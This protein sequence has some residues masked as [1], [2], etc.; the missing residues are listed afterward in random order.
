MTVNH[1][2]LSDINFIREINN[3]KKIKPPCFSIA[4]FIEKNRIMPASSPLPGPVDL[5][6]T[7]Y[8]RE[9][10]SNMSPYS[11]IQHQIIK[12]S[13]QVAATFAVENIMG[14]Y[15][16][17]FP[18]AILYISA[19]QALLEKF[20]TKRLEPLIDSCGIRP[21]IIENANEAFGTKSRRTGDKIFS[22]Q[23]VS[24]F[25]EL[26]SAQSPAS[27]RSDTIRVLIRDETEGAKKNL[28]TG[29]GSFL[30]VSEARVKFFGARKKITDLSTPALLEDSYIDPAY[31]EGDKRLYRMPCPECGKFIDFYPIPEEGNFGLRGIIEKGRL[32]EVYYICEHCQF[33]IL[34]KYKQEM[35]I[36][37]KWVPTAISKSEFYRSYYINSLYSPVGT[38]AWSDYYNSWLSSKT[39]HSK[40]RAFTNLAAGLSYQEKG[41]RPKFSAITHLRGNYKRMTLPKGV[42]F[43]T[44]TIDVQRG[45]QKFEKMSDAEI[46]AY[47]KKNPD[48]KEKYPRLEMGIMGHGSGYRTW[49]INHKVFIGNLHHIETGAWGRVKEFYYD[50]AKKGT[51]VQNGKK[52][53]SII[54][55]DDG[56]ELDLPINFVDARDGSM[57]STVSSFCHM[58]GDGFFPSM[59]ANPLKK[60]LKDGG[61]KES[62]GIDV[63]KY[64]PRLLDQ[65][66]YTYI[67][68]SNYY[69]KLI[70]MRAKIERVA[71]G[72]QRLGF[73]DHPADFPDE[74][75]KQ[76]FA[77][78]QLSDGSFDAGGRAGILGIC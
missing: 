66:Q 40:D 10:L 56:F 68:S 44:A 45:S 3:K 47:K 46:L 55:P 50:L 1:Q 57:T 28:N 74:Y 16:R 61:D 54:D 69:K 72:E 64:R 22:K 24:G 38:Y 33:H 5:D 26:A 2:L 29:E 71:V 4:E 52:L 34:E 13:A 60:I 48:K 65:S 76:L 21:L 19:T 51:M 25:L 75:F 30:D 77:E 37:G 59:G 73:M 43:L 58:M 35:L 15:M 23:F 70:Y 6:L 27:L 49:M 42:L 67:I 7:P 9:W 62:I 20:C 78:V 11:P 32:K 63:Q 17:E 53:S 31:E 36:A 14:F 12:K 41:D 8:I 18:T 39:D